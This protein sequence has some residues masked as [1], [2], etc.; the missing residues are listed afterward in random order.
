MSALSFTR[1][2]QKK[3]LAGFI[4]RLHRGE[5]PEPIKAG[6]KEVMRDLSPHELARLEGELMCER[7]PRDGIL[8]LCALHLDLLH[9]ACSKKRSVAAL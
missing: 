7:V 5:N 3:L 1:L 2:H 4:Q 6:L 8:M 9:E